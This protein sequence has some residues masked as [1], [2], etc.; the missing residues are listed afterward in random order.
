M[1]ALVA[2]SAGIPAEL[3]PVGLYLCILSMCAATASSLASFL[4][5]SHLCSFTVFPGLTGN[6]YHLTCPMTKHAP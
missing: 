6:N 2:S 5:S 1:F 4:L 3:G